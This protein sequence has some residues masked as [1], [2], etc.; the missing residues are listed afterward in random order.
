MVNTWKKYLIRTIGALC[1]LGAVALMFIGGWVEMKDMD[2]KELRNVRGKLEDCTAAAETAYIS[3]LK[4]NRMFKDE[5]KD[6]DLPT[7]SSKAKADIKEIDSLV[8]SVLDETVSFGELL[9]LTIRAPHIVEKTEELVESDCADSLFTE[10]A[11]RMWVDEYWQDAETTYEEV[12]AMARTDGQQFADMSETLVDG[13]EEFSMVVLLLMVALFM[14]IVLGVGA[15]ATHISNRARWL[16]YIFLALL[17]L[18]TVGTMVATSA[19]SEMVGEQVG[20]PFADLTLSITVTPFFAI[21][22]MIVP[23]VLDVVSERKKRYQ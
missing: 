22:L 9:D 8:D 15:A 3:L 7:S 23:V 11:Y 18:L 10:M 5:A 19:V 14:I 20:G 2:K 1:I 6:C 21:A 13:Y 16:K 17:V 4:E 12:R